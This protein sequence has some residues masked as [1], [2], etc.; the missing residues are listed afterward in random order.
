M[1]GIMTCS[2]CG[3]RSGRMEICFQCAMSLWPHRKVNPA[4]REL[5]RQLQPV[6]SKY[7]LA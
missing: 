2:I 1:I 7:P 5:A 4:A 6:P 3:Q